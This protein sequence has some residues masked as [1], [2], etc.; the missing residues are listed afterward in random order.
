MSH[1]SWSRA[2]YVFF[3][4]AVLAA[5]LKLGTSGLL[6]AEP[7]RQAFAKSQTLAETT[8]NQDEQT[9]KTSSAKAVTNGTGA[10]A[11]AGEVTASVADN[12]A[13]TGDSVAVSR[14]NK[15]STMPRQTEDGTPV[16]YRSTE[17]STKEKAGGARDVSPQKGTPATAPP[18]TRSGSAGPVCGN[19]RD[20]PKNSK[21]VFPLSKDYFNSYDDTWGAARPQGGHEGTDLM[22]PMKTP[23]YAMTD[24][25]IVPVSGANNNGWNTLGGYTVMLRADYSVGPVQKGDLFYYAHMDRKAPLAIGTRVRAGQLIGYAGDTGQGPEITR[26]L[27]PPH[28][29]LGWYDTSGVRTNLASGAMNPFPL[30]EWIKSNGGA[31]SGGTDAKFCTAPQKGTPTPST[32]EQDWTFPTD[33]GTR[34]DMDT[35]TDRAA[36]SPTV[37]KA[38]V[39]AE[40]ATRQAPDG[41]SKP[42]K[43]LNESLDENKLGKKKAG[44]KP[45]VKPG[46]N[47]RK[48]EKPEPETAEAETAVKKKISKQIDK[49]ERLKVPGARKMIGWIQNLVDGKIQNNRKAPD[50]GH[51]ASGENHRNK[52]KDAGKPGGEARPGKPS[53][54]G[55]QAAKKKDNCETSRRNTP[56]R[57]GKSKNRVESKKDCGNTG[58]SKNGTPPKT[59][60]PDSETTND[61]L[62]APREQP[63]KQPNEDTTQK[64]VTNEGKPPEKEP[65]SQDPEDESPNAEKT[66]DDVPSAE[67]A[68]PVSEPEAPAEEE[69]TKEVPADE[70]TE[71]TTAEAPAE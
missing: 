31:V 48:K 42:D 46:K 4:L 15:T 55:D 50:G 28:L 2:A 10:K 23:E 65:S 69:T 54:D 52:P 30:L 14:K 25:T 13:A 11:V 3:V 62:K 61:E 20:A 26:G 43:K 44:E 47:V 1:I 5:L 24:G 21:I 19:L 45:D 60:A 29:H 27:F 17:R 16:F 58:G 63:G 8:K 7:L 66:A 22:T 6:D 35:G 41:V 70:A 9:A 67:P 57:S 64:E 12:A 51:K 37:Q 59:T 36:P 49:P 68:N 18:A 33:P 34:P 53:A 56:A 39:S 71:P 38:P 32:G 40:K